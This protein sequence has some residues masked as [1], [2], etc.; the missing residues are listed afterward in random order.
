MDYKKYFKKNEV[1][2]SDKDRIAIKVGGLITAARLHAGLSQA[3]LAKKI[4]TQQPSIARAESGE[5]VPSIE[6]LFKVSKAIKDDFVF[7][8]F[9]FMNRH[10]SNSTTVIDKSGIPSYFDC[11]MKPQL[12]LKETETGSLVSYS[13]NKKSAVNASTNL[14]R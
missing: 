1:N 12:V 4:G 14:A 9:G 7:P 11:E 3:D 2:L 8:E 6:F 5:V 13:E 10:I